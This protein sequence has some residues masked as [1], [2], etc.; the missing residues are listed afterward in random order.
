MRCCYFFLVFSLIAA[1]SLFGTSNPHT[2]ELQDYVTQAHT[3]QDE[4]R[5][6]LALRTYFAGLAANPDIIDL[7]FGKK[8][9]P[10]SFENS[11]RLGAVKLPNDKLFVTG[12][13][14]SGKTLLVYYKKGH[15]DTLQFSRYLPRLITAYS[16]AKI[17]FVPQ[18][19]LIELFKSSLNSLGDR[20]EVVS[21]DNITSLNYD[22][23]MH[24]LSV[25]CAVSAGLYDIPLTDHYLQISNRPLP[26]LQRIGLK[27]GLIW[28]G[29]PNHIHDKDRSIPLHL[30]AQLRN[31]PGVI[32]YS[33]QTHNGLDQLHDEAN[34]WDD[35][36]IDLGQYCKTFADTA[37]FMNQMDVIVSIDSASAH[38]ACALGKKNI[39][40][41]PKYPDLRWVGDNTT[42]FW[43]QHSI[44]LRQTEHGDWTTELEM[45]RN[46][47]QEQ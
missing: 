5:Y 42:N 34:G 17:L 38:L 22:Y 31:I 19:P 10:S 25:P 40:F 11:T 43:C 4:G 47:L 9:A 32:F 24:L 14:I 23:H 37:A 27:V 35:D 21:Q 44:L 30:F 18:N 7:Q 20:I 6:D 15:G 13:D 46:I 29:D 8:L 1:T 26:E 36:L 41:I 45:L 39:I 16:P 3:Y 12:M 33:L 28:Q 2:M